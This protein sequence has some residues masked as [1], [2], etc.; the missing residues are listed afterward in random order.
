MLTE[1]QCLT[2]AADFT[3]RAKLSEKED[4]RSFNL[5]VAAGWLRIA[6]MAAYQDGWHRL[7]QIN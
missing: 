5:A 4:D 2:K 7:N 6:G 3:D 1:T